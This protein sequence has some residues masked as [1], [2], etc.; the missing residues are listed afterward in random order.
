MDAADLFSKHVSRLQ[1]E[2]EKWLGESGFDS[3]V[4]SSGAPFTFFVDDRDA[5]FEPT[6]HFAHWCPLTGPH[7]LLHVIP[8]R[9]PRV[10]R[11][12]PEDY[13]YEQGGVTEAFWVPE[14]YQTYK[15][16]IFN[17]GHSG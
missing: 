11:Y 7:H 14:G 9:R 16:A 1:S 17:S 3:L 8:G 2:T 15:A 4:V 10:I 12:A 6:P 5:P 13:W